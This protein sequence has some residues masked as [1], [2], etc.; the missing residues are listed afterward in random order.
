MICQQVKY[1]LSLFKSHVHD[2]TAIWI[3]LIIINVYNIEFLS[4]EIPN[5]KDRLNFAKL[6]N[7]SFI[8]LYILG[9]NCNSVS[10]ILDRLL[11]VPSGYEAAAFGII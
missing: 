9:G 11:C 5:Y 8:I 6:N 4:F 7:G 1:A 3:A 10:L 2:K